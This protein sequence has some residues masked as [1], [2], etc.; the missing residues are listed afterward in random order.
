M[1]LIISNTNKK[2]N[3]N[4]PHSHGAVQA[5]QLQWQSSSKFVRLYDISDFFALNV[6]RYIVFG[7]IGAFLKLRSF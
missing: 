5:M 1:S 6:N 3:I 4:V 2:V 7:Y